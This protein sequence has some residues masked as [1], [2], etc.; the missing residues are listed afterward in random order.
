LLP[1]DYSRHAIENNLALL[2]LCGGSPRLSS[3]GYEVFLTESETAWAREFIAQRGLGARAVLG[4]HVGSGGTKNLAMRR[5]P[6]ENYVE[7][8]RQIIRHCPQCSV[9][10]F[11]GPEEQEDH[12]KIKTVVDASRVL[13]P[14]TN[15]LRQAAALIKHCRAFLSV[16]TALMHVAAAM[17]VPGQIVIETPTWNRPIEPYG[18]AFTL[19]KNPAIAGRNLDWYRYDGKGIQGTDEEIVSC[20]KSVTVDAV[21]AAVL[22]VMK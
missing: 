5:W 2:Q 21:L 4:I 18:N 14:P 20:V 22:E 3:H 17:R 16:D 9:L 13:F 12:E 8:I 19:V 11:G 15:N 7:L 6:V 10:L 1:Q